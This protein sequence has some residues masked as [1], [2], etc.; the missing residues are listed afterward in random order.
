MANVKGEIDSMTSGGAGKLTVQPLHF[1]SFAVYCYCIVEGKR[2]TMEYYRG[3]QRKKHIAAL[4]AGVVCLTQAL[5]LPVSASCT[6]LPED[7]ESDETPLVLVDDT[8]DARPDGDF[9]A[10]TEAEEDAG[11]GG[12][13]VG[14]AEGAEETLIPDGRWEAVFPGVICTDDPDFARALLADGLAEYVEEDGAAYLFDTETAPVKD[15]WVYE[16]V[17]AAYADTLGLS[18]EGVRVAVIDSG[19]DLTNA[20]LQNA[21]IEIGYDYLRGTGKRMRDTM[22]HGTEVAQMIAAD[23][24]EKGS[25]GIARGVTIVPLLCYDERWSPVSALVHAIWDA[26]DVYHCDII[27]MSWGTSTDY[28]T[29]HEALQYAYESGCI[30]VAAAGNVSYVEP[31]GTLSYP[32]AYDEV[33]G[34][35]SVAPTMD[36]S[37]FSQQTSAVYVCAPGDEVPVWINGREKTTSG[38]SFASPCVAAMLALAKERMPSL[39]MEE[40]WQLLQ[41]RAVDRGKAGY[42]KVFGYGTIDVRSLLA[43]SWGC[44]RQE[45]DATILYGWLRTDCRNMAALYTQNGQLV[46]CI[47]LPEQEESDILCYELPQVTGEL[48]CKVF[49][50]DGNYRPT[51]GTAGSF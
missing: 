50:L 27:N 3:K 9:A 40:A 45:G 25:T 37:T 16:A 20:D 49:S 15:G 28:K 18:G 24:N 29:L 33:I 12:Y 8:E 19:V 47:S 4:L 13:L 34:V 44:C 39:T 1:F 30:L 21:N 10:L 41:D 22:G 48:R 17:D 7:A 36:I 43:P 14:L 46:A 32:A 23:R 51:G 42:D 6:L 2:N 31:Q 5:L 35:G 11:P 38:T 26:V